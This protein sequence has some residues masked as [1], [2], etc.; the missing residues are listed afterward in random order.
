MLYKN[1]PRSDWRRT[2]PLRMACDLAALGRTLALGN[3]QEAGAILRAYR[4]AFRM[5]RHYRDQRPDPSDRTVR[6]PYRGLVPVDYFLRGRRRFSDLPS[7]NFTP[8]A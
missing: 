7:A 6:P 4:D 2:L 5:R 1:L 3:K 8:S